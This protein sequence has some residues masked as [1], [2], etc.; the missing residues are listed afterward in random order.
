MPEIT[1]EATRLK[2][3]GLCR[4]SVVFVLKSFLEDGLA[5]WNSGVGAPLVGALVE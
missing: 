4:D 1:E 2:L 5:E 3:R